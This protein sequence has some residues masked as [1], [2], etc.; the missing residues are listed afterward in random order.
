MVSHGVRVQCPSIE[1]LHKYPFELV[2][3]ISLQFPRLLSLHSRTMIIPFKYDT[4]FPLSVPSAH[5]VRLRLQVFIKLP[6]GVDVVE[7]LPLDQELALAPAH[8]PLHLWEGIHHHDT[9]KEQSPLHG[10]AAVERIQ[11]RWTSFCACQDDK[12]PV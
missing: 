6:G 4:P 8:N 5:L 9:A 10:R 12:G 2:S 3:Q 11:T 7:A 1:G